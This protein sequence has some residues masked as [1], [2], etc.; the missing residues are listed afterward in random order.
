MI[1]IRFRN[2]Q[3]DFSAALARAL[4]LGAGSLHIA[5]EHLNAADVARAHAAGVAVYVYTVNDAAA[6]A[7][8]RAAAVDGVFSDYPD[9]V[10]A[11]RS[12]W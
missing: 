6:I 12:G 1:R 10:I 8:C 7:Q 5:L 4:T 2:T 11:A 9:R 3:Q